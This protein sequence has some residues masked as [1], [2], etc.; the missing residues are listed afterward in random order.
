M[1]PI[2]QLAIAFPFLAAL[3]FVS[4]MA[5]SPGY[6]FL[7]TVL[8]VMIGPI[9]AMTVAVA[10]G[11]P[12]RLNRRLSRWWLGNTLVYILLAAAG[13]GLIIAGFNTPEHQVGDIDGY[14]YDVVT[15]HTGFLMSGC[16][17]VTFLAVNAGFPRRIRKRPRTGKMPQ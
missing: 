17:I 3:W 16:F 8:F 15:R 9:F 13:V 7:G 6:E 5:A 4:V 2:S 11:L 1:A 14:H 10:V 12:L